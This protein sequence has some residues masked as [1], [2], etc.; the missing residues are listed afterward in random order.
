MWNKVIGAFLLASSVLLGEGPYLL[1]KPALSKTLAFS[2]AGDL[3]IVSR[4]G[5]EAIRLTSGPGIETGPNR[6]HRRIRWECGRVRDARQRR[7]AEAFDLPSRH[8]PGYGLD[9]GR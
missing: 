7:S 9:R 6:A 2:F 1:R 8:R 4:A 5:G 3:W